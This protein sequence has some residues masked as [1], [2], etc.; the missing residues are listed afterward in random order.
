MNNTIIALLGYIGW[1]VL[2]LVWLETYRTLRVLKKEKAPNEFSTDGSD[3]NP[4]GQRLTRAFGNCLESFAFIGGPM[5]LAIASGAAAITNPL[6][7]YL[8]VAR[9]GQSV[10]HLISSSELA[11]QIRFAFFLVQQGIVIYWVYLLAMNFWV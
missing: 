3:M 7:L 5:L 11:V 10:I 6:A 4:F 1:T 2:L 9:L 8:L